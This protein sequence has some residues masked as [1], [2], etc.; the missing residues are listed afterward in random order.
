MCG[1]LVIFLGAIFPRFTLV[2]I[3]LFTNWNDRA[4]DSFWIGLVGWIFLPYSTLAYSAMNALGDPI[5]GFGWAIVVLG[6]VAD[7]G[8]WF[9]TSSRDRFAS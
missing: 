9:G 3:E 8:G 1:C 4:F 7:V 5:N 2:V 6:F